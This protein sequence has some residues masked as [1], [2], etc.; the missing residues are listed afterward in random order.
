[1]C[2]HQLGVAAVILTT[3]NLVSE[4]NNAYTFKLKDKI[5]LLAKTLL[6]CKFTR[7]KF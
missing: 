4:Q 3:I 5:V 6:L 2:I 7:L 1:M